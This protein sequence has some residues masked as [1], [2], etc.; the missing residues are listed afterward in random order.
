MD[1]NAQNQEN[2]TE[3]QTSNPYKEV[4]MMA[5]KIPVPEENVRFIVEDLGIERILRNADIDEVVRYIGIEDRLRGVDVEDL[6]KLPDALLK[7]FSREDLKRF[8]ELLND[9]I[10]NE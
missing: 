3:S 5:G 6:Q 7:S 2:D 10:T 1:E 8:L 4:L 9:K